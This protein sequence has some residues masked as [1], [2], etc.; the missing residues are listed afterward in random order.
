VGIELLGDPRGT[1]EVVVENGGDIFIKVLEPITVGIY[2]GSSPLS[3]KVGLKIR[4][5]E[6]YTSVCTSSG[7]V[8]HSLSFGKADAVCVVSSS[9]SLADAVAT[10]TGN[11]VKS[12]KDIS[13]GIEFAKEIPG[14]AGV[15]VILGGELGVWGDVEL[16]SIGSKKNLN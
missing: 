1:G 4:P 13:R 6:G 5:C 16:V 9:C 2:A 12:K 10:A 3:L 7:T 15:V 14:V 11:R 8:G